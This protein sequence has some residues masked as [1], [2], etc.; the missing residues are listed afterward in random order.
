[1]SARIL[2]CAGLGA[3]GG[4]TS[5]RASPAAEKRVG[6]PAFA[7]P[8]AT[9]GGGEGGLAFGFILRVVMCLP[10][11]AVTIIRTRSAI[12]RMMERPSTKAH[13]QSGAGRR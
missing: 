13:V 5:A 12:P 8:V 7:V 6:S 9:N 11:A 10:T 4:V 1:M 3:P 2:S